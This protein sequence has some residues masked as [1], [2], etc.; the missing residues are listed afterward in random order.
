M[1]PMIDC[2]TYYIFSNKAWCDDQWHALIKKTEPLCTKIG[3]VIAVPF[4]IIATIFSGALF[5]VSRIYSWINSEISSANSKPDSPVQESSKSS[6]RI[7][8]EVTT[9]TNLLES[10]V[11]TET[12]TKKQPLVEYQKLLQLHQ[13]PSDSLF[14][15]ARKHPDRNRFFNVLPNE[16]T[17][18]KF[19][20]IPE[21]YFNANWT[22]DGIAIASQGPLE[23]EITEF[24]EMVWHSDV[25]TLVMLA[26]PIEKGQNKCSEYW[27]GKTSPGLAPHR[28]L[29]AQAL[30]EKPIYNEGNVKIV[31]RTIQVSKGSQSKTI[32]QYHLQ[33]WP[34][35]GVVRPT[36][37]A[38]LIKLVSDKTKKERFLAHCSAGIG[39]TGTFLAA[40]QAFQQK[41]FNLFGIASDLRSPHKGR[42]GMI[43]TPEQ[44]NLAKETIELLLS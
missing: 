7:P 14:S 6:E 22:L 24:W 19:A 28:E 42:I 15:E 38:H 4:L 16:P 31:E 13:S 34:D 37:L 41:T 17:R 25:N 40:F 9:P 32:T 8:T 30:S 12:P 1:L 20:N 29:N 10:P 26:N 11:P 2:G 43:Q 3:R 39:R 27:K 23:T 35:F 36:V 33:N 44:Y 21:F 18:V 5:C